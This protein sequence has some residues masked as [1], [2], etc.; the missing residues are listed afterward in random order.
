M[1]DI[2]ASGI[3]RQVRVATCDAKLINRESI[4]P[5]FWQDM[6]EVSR[7]TCDVA[8]GLFDRY[9]RVERKYTEP[10][11]RQGTGVWGRELDQGDILLIEKLR[12]EAGARRRGVGTK[13]AHEVL[14]HVRGSTGRGKYV[15]VVGPGMG[16]QDADE[17]NGDEAMSALAT[18]RRFWRSL[19]FRRVGTSPW[20][21]FTDE[22]GHPSRQLNVSKEWDPPQHTGSCVAMPEH[23]RQAIASVLRISSPNAETLRQLEEALPDTA[24]DER[25]LATDEDGNTVL[26]LAAIKGSL[27]VVKCIVNRCPDLATARNREGDT[28]LEAL[29]TAMEQLRTRRDYEEMLEVVSDQFSGFGPRSA[30]CVG[31]L[32]GAEALFDLTQLSREEIAKISSATDEEARLIHPE[33]DAIRH[34]LR[35]K[36]GCTCGACLGGFL[37][38]RMK[39]LLMEQPAFQLDEDSIMADDEDW[40]EQGKQMLA[41]RFTECL[42]KGMIPSE[43]NILRLVPDDEQQTLEAFLEEGGTVNHHV[44]NIFQRIQDSDD[45]ELLLGNDPLVA[46]VYKELPECRNDLELGFV[47]GMCGYKRVSPGRQYYHD[48]LM[49]EE[50]EG[51][52]ADDE[53]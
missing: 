7:E 18:A 50:A 37:S 11:F 53:I 4:R 8:F 29:Q 15:A 31:F 17:T 21:A 39:R 6:E 19:G 28:P 46:D 13:V 10:G 48:G 20:F 5:S 1:E 52:E 43:D 9:G 44:S 38:P 45:W 47:S 36:Y 2:T 3:E 41:N 24:Q 49:D 51:E 12:V 34:A 26:H 23:V 32:S 16:L 25:W 30:A 33:A 27:E 22:V 14:D 35:L 42:E 40:M